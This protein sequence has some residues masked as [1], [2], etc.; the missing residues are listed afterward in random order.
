VAVDH[1]MIVTF[2]LTMVAPCYNL[3]VVSLRQLCRIAPFVL[4]LKILNQGIRLE[5]AR[6]ILTVWIEC[7]SI[8]RYSKQ[9]WSNMFI[10]RS[11]TTNNTACDVS[12]PVTARELLHI[13]G[14]CRI[15]AMA[16]TIQ[17]QLAFRLKLVRNFGIAS[18]LR[19]VQ[20]HAQLQCVCVGV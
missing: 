7:S 13:F 9:R 10:S 4:T 5:L 2:P 20:S 17:L 18:L 12:S 3:K 15:R 8:R 6:V 1:W 19:T 16:F 14:K 11:C